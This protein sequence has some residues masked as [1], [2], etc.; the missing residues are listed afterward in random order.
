MKRKALK[1]VVVGQAIALHFERER[2]DGYARAH[3]KACDLLDEERS[4]HGATQ[5]ELNALRQTR[6]QERAVPK[7]EGVL[8]ERDRLADELAKAQ[9]TLKL[10]DADIEMRDADLDKERGKVRGLRSRVS[11]QQ[12]DLDRMQAQ[13]ADYRRQ[14]RELRLSPRARGFEGAEGPDTDPNHVD[15]GGESYGGSC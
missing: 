11:M 10:R 13:A 2:A 14:I 15:A 7:V 9:D 1:K 3:D 8:A 4:R 5:G 6:A 12:L